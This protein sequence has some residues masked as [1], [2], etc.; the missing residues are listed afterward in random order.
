M[1]KGNLYAIFGHSGLLL[2]SPVSDCGSCLAGRNGLYLQHSPSSG[3]VSIIT[4]AAMAAFFFSFFSFGLLWFLQPPAGYTMSAMMQM[5]WEFKGS[6]RWSLHCS[7]WETGPA[8]RFAPPHALQGLQL[9]IVINVAVQAL[10]TTAAPRLTYPDHCRARP[11]H[12]SDVSLHHST[13]TAWQG[14]GRPYWKFPRT[15]QPSNPIWIY[16]HLPNDTFIDTL[17]R[18]QKI[19]LRR[20]VIDVLPLQG[21]QSNFR[22]NAPQPWSWSK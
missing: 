21:H 4:C 2:A 7:T 9:F 19:L 13:P 18:Y 6:S 5:G 1:Q 3:N 17:H 10:W 20:Q 8:G 16:M 14:C 12:H 22:Q 11:C 15:E